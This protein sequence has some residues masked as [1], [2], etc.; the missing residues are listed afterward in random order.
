MKRVL[1]P[2]F[3]LLVLGASL[4]AQVVDTTVCA[5]IKNPTSFDGKMI[6]I[7]ATAAAGFDQFILKDGDCG[8]PVNGIWL[9]YPQGTKGK[10]G[11]AAVVEIEPAHNFTGKYAAPTR[12]AVTLEKDKNFKQFDSWLA[13]QHSVAFGICLG[14]SRYEVT[15]TFVGRLDGVSDAT[16]KRDAKG[17]VTGFG[18]FGNMNAY[19]ARLVLQSVSDVAR[20]EV[21]YSSLEALTRKDQAQQPP[22]SS[23]EHDPIAAAQKA[24]TAMGANPAGAAALKD[25]AVYGKPGEQNGVVIGFGAADEAAPEALGTADSPDGVLYNCTFN[26]ERLHENAMGVALIHLGQ[27]ISDL[28]SVAADEFAPTYGL[29][30]NAWV[31]TAS[32]AVSMGNRYVTLPGGTVFFAMSWPA[33]DRESKMIDALTTFLTKE[34]LLT[35]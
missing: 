2:A 20:K 6:R 16:L 23:D 29:E 8:A 27:H 1:F 33:A 25:A 17:K 5:V 32:A 9:D 26:K 24:A 11:P 19:A 4:H 10:A 21:D 15:G 7:K 28:R 31:V 13:Q 18:G 35:K 12:A 3:F 34:A 22:A 30:Y 14:C